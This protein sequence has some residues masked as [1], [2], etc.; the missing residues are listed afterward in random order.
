MSGLQKH[1][2]AGVEC[3]QHLERLVIAS[4]DFTMYTPRTLSLVCFRINGSNERNTALLDACNKTGEVF[5][6]HT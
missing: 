3:A 6:I 4:S 5:L 2:R 1:I